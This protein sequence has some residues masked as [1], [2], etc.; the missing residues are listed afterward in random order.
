VATD[1][2]LIALLVAAASGWAVIR[3]ARLMS[4][5]GVGFEDGGGYTALLLV[6]LTVNLA[7]VSVA[8]S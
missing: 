7:A 2:K 6:A 1:V 5:H 8:L 3:V 4:F